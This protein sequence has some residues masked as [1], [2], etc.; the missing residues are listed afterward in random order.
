MKYALETDVHAIGGAQ[1]WERKE[2]EP[3]M[4]PRV[5]E[6]ADAQG[7]GGRTSPRVPPAALYWL[8][9]V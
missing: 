4:H 2:T 3:R 1:R 6:E 9:V 5:W 7:A 8:N